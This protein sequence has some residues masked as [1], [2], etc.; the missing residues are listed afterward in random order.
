MMLAQVMA[1]MMV[2]TTGDGAA[3]PSIPFGGTDFKQYYTTSRLLRE[4]HNPY[5]YDR[6]GPLQKELGNRGETQVPYGPPTSLLPFIPL[7]WVDFTTA[8]QIQLG[9]NLVMLCLSCYL[10]GTLFLP[11]YPLVSIGIIGCWVPTW[12]LLGLGQ[13][14]SWL[15]LGF[16][17]WYWAMKHNRPVLAGAMLNLVIMKPHLGFG[18][19]VYALVLGYRD[20]QW[21]MLAAFFVTFAVIIAATFVIRPTIWHEWYASLE[22]SKP[23]KW[24]NATLDGWGKAFFEQHYKKGKYFTYAVS[25]PICAAFLALVLYLTWTRPLQDKLGVLI[26]AIWLAASPYAF[27]YDFSLLIPAIIMT[28]SMVI[29]RSHPL[30]LLAGVG[31]CCLSLIFYVTKGP[32]Q[33]HDWF[34]FPLSGLAITLLLTGLGERS[35][36]KPA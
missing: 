19:V 12:M 24:A 30:A 3:V 18:L 23:D 20:K 28:L 2:C 1:L 36:P 8:I 17:V 25:L 21:K 35:I 27:S 4:G 9:L 29:A 33:E 14:S 26:L 32:W 5:D 34:F 6:A 13:V 16:T 7:G 31:W 10:W 15:L 11:K 22:I